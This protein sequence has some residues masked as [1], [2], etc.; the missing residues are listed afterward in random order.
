MSKP[1]KKPL[2]FTHVQL[3]NWRNF[4]QVDV[5]LQRRTFFVG[6]NASGKSNFLDVFRF[7]HDIAVAGGGFQA[8][9]G[10]PWRGGVAKI[11]SLAARHHADVGIRVQIGDDKSARR[12]EYELR[13]AQESYLPRIKQE[14]VLRQ[15]KELL[16][17]PS[18]QD[19]KDPLRLTQTHLEQVGV[20]YQ[21]RELADFFAS[22]RYLHLLPQVVRN[23]VLAIG[24]N[25]PFGGD[26]LRGMADLPEQERK[27]RLRIVRDALRAAVPQLQELEFWLDLGEK[28][29]HLRAKHKHFEGA[30]QLEDQ[31]SDGTLRLL[32][33]LWAIS[34][35]AG[36]L[37]L[38]EPELSLHRDVI[39]LLA[40]LFAGL[41]A[42]SGRQVLLSTH[43]AELLHDEGIGLNEVVVLEPG[44]EGT[45]ASLAGD[46]EQT[47]V[48]VESGLDMGEAVLPRAAPR[49]A[50]DML[51][52]DGSHSKD[53]RQKVAR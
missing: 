50:L 32:G 25:D 40:P 16:R 22:V 52:V 34:E 39:R 7:L 31:F 27:E 46:D 53:K 29:P 6:P 4:T 44:T 35:T 1:S 28:K 49:H 19:E 15:G 33:L 30:W 9:L 41:Q 26:L 47:R 12:W 45:V 48:L 37:L 10:K 14:R 5:S 38:E 21:F 24:Q 20:N 11:K 36:P 17:R 8:A 42:R 51:L 43:S 23:L 13:L 2:R 18:S 3:E